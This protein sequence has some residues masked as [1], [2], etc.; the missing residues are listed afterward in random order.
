MLGL[1]TAVTELL[2][3]PQL[4]DTCVRNGIYDEALDLQSF[5][6]RLGLLHPELPVV[7]LLMEQVVILHYN[8][9]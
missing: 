1:Q 8:C 2:E 6:S 4:M 7:Q 9:A 3:S 5:V